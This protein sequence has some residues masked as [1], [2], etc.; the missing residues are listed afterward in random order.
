MAIGRPCYSI[1]GPKR[2]TYEHRTKEERSIPKI[3]PTE[4][5]NVGFTKRPG[6][7]GSKN[8]R[9]KRKL[10]R[11]KVKKINSKG[12]RRVT[13]FYACDFS[14]NRHCDCGPLISS[15]SPFYLRCPQRRAATRLLQLLVERTESVQTLQIMML[16]PVLKAAVHNEC[17]LPMY[18][19]AGLESTQKNKASL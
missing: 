17:G 19:V 10:Q 18:A 12:R 5:A 11:E 6:R 3:T 13:G 9:K 16:W 2:L 1:G 15:P 8:A 7:S 14:V 4:G